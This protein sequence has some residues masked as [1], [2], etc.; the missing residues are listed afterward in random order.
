[1]TDMKIE[2]C[3]LL[4]LLIE[5]MWCMLSPSERYK[6][7]RRVEKSRSV[8]K[9]ETVDSEARDTPGSVIVI[10][11][12]VLDFNTHATVDNYRVTFVNVHGVELVAQLIPAEDEEQ[13]RRAARVM[14]GLGFDWAVKT[15]ELISLG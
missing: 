7:N 1:M 13:A 11:P 9:L 15:V 3:Q 8:L 12:F 14:T 4:L 6:V 5:E 10:Q 2:D